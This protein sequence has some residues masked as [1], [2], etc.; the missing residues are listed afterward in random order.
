MERIITQLIQL[1]QLHFTLLEQRTLVPEGHLVDLENSIRTLMEEL[2]PKIATL[3]RTLQE[4]HDVAVVPETK[5]TCS[6]CGIAL[7]TSLTSEILSKKGIQQCPNC[8]RILYPFEGAPGQLSKDLKKTGKPRAGV[9]KFSSA[10]LML[11]QIEA[12]DRDAAIAELI[13]LMAEQ[14]FVGN[15]EGLLRAALGREAIVSTALDHGLAFPHVRGVEAGGLT[16]ALGLKKRGFKF[17]PSQGRLTRIV[18]FIV[19][20][21]AVSVFYLQ[22]LAGLIKAFQEEDAR[23][24]ILACKTSEEMWTALK[25]LTKKTIP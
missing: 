18:F 3:Y 23:K 17:D 21:S 22:V 20:P 24:Q 19:I 11:P 8:M 14:G 16:F 15:P 7:P 5:G 1:Q 2:P 4:R 13:Q 25:R 10:E 6:A 12:G 9:A